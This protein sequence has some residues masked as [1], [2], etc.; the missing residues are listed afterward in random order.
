MSVIYFLGGILFLWMA[1]KT[2]EQ[3][4]SADTKL[5]DL[6]LHDVSEYLFVI[7]CLVAGVMLIHKAF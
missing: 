4:K 5:S 7:L 6:T 3:Q 2:L 1:I